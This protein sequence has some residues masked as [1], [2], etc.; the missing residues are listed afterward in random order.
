MT[1]KGEKVKEDIIYE[2]EWNPVLK[3]WVVLVGR[4]IEIGGKTGVEYDPY[5]FD[6]KELGRAFV[7]GKLE[8]RR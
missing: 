3:Q 5:F 8:E 7:K 6:S 4:Y 2:S 1:K